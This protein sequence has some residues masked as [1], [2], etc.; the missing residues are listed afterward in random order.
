[1]MIH[2]RHVLVLNKNW[3]PVETVTLQRAI[4]ML[5][6]TYANG[7]PKAKIVEYPSYE[8]YTWNDWSKLKPIAT[9]DVIKTANVW[10]RVPEVILLTRYG[11][12]P[13]PEARYSRRNLY[14]RDN[15]QCQY[16]L[17]KPGPEELTIDHVLPKSKGGQ[18]TWENTVLACIK[19]NSKKADRSLKDSKMKLHTIP[20]KPKGHMAIKC[21]ALKPID[22]WKAF[23]SEAYWSVELENDNK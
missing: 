18:T 22:S 3:A 11:K 12:V 6:T 10:F 2:T 5:F 21:N 23:I 4:T 7:E 20:V 8:T 9:D 13:Q 16:C 17:S 19:C 15:Y 1:M 14:K